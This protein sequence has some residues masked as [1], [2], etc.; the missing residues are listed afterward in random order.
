M[1]QGGM[2]H[3]FVKMD[4]SFPRTMP[5]RKVKALCNQPLTKEGKNGPG[6]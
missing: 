5:R 3:D 2:A 1:E 4:S 6:K